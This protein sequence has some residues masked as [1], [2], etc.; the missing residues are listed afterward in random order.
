MSHARVVP[1][2]SGTK[3]LDQSCVNKNNNTKS[4]SYSKEAIKVKGEYVKSA[5]PC[6]VVEKTYAHKQAT[7]HEKRVYANGTTYYYCAGVV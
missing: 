3:K 6:N 4:G 1:Q 5:I 2:R 7:K